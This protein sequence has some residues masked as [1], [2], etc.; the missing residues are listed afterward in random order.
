MKDRAEKPQEP[1]ESSTKPDQ[2]SSGNKTAA[3]NNQGGKPG[4]HKEKR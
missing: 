1:V 3:K 2:A 4:A